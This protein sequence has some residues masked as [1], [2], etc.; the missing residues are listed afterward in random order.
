MTDPTPT[1]DEDWSFEEEDENQE[2]TEEPLEGDVEQEI[3]DE[4]SEDYD[5]GD[6]TSSLAANTREKYEEIKEE[7]TKR[8][9]LKG[10][11]VGAAGVGLLG[12][13]AY[14]ASE[15]LDTVGEPADPDPQ[16]VYALDDDIEVNLGELASIYEGSNIRMGVQE[17]GNLV[18]WNRNVQNPEGQNPLWRF[19]S[20]EF[21]DREHYDV[22]THPIVQ[23]YE[24]SDAE[25]RTMSQNM[26]EVFEEDNWEDHAEYRRVNFE[27]LKDGL[28][29]YGGTGQAQDYFFNRTETL[30]DGE[31]VL[32]REWQ[33]LLQDGL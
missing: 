12:F 24:E 22:E 13:A 10:L 20:E 4:E 21:P 11:G 14:G 29:E 17:N 8:D 32:E 1:D 6:A 30:R 9:F 23:I 33:E 5:G 31:A 28:I 19:N 7:T 27:E 25:V 15:T 16:E 3:L 2:L 18:A 26:V